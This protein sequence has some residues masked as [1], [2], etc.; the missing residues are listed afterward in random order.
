M[1]STAGATAG[2]AAGAAMLP[3]TGLNLVW[4]AVAAFT[5]ISAGFAMMRLVPR[6]RRG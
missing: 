5:L 1:Y 4:Y 6:R 3:V 2:T